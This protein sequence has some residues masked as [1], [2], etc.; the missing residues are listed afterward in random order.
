MSMQT[1]TARN[2]PFLVAG[3]LALISQGALSGETVATDTALEQL[4]VTAPRP[5]VV[6]GDL[7]IETDAAAMIEAMNRRVAKD[8]EKNLEVVGPARIELVTSEV[9]TRG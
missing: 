5:E 6:I 4:T 2:R 3:A 7:T 8:L 1:V 9:A